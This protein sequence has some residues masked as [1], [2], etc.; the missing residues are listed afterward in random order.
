MDGTELGK[1]LWIGPIWGQIVEA[2]SVYLL[3]ECFLEDQK[4]ACWGG[5]PWTGKLLG[6]TMVGERYK[7]L[8]GRRKGHRKCHKIL[9]SEFLHLYSNQTSGSAF[10]VHLSLMFTQL[11]EIAEAKHH[12]LRKLSFSEQ[13]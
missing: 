8:A 13:Q 5:A 11:N 2:R 4:E 9:A 3:G 6:N 1:S 7:E 10:H 12:R